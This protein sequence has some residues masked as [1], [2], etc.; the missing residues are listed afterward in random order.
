M[1]MR[2][3]I[4]GTDKDTKN[5]QAALT[6]LGVPFD[7]LLEN[8]EYDRYDR[9]LLPGGGDIAPEFFGQKNEGSKEIDEVLDR[10]QFAIFTAVFN[11]GKPVLGICR[12]HQVINVALGGDLI[13]DLPTAADHK[14]PTPAEDNHHIAIAEPGSLMERLYGQEFPVNSAHHQGL[15]RIGRGLKVTMR[16]ADGVVEAIEHE[17]RPVIGLQWHPERT[18][19][20]FLSDRAVDGRKVL[21]Y[22]LAIRKGV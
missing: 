15:G 11:A 17:S 1:E 16:A 5:Y 4:A 9:L 14:K 8:I 3:L 10:K 20:A 18:G 21:E 7:V 19:F 13:Q 12:G 22:F 6:A 2:V